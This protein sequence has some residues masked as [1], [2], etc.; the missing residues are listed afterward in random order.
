MKNQEIIEGLAQLPKFLT[1]DWIDQAMNKLDKSKMTP[2]Q[3]MH[4]E[5]MLAKNGSILSMMEE[6]KRN[7]KEEVTK[8]VTKKRAEELA[9][10]MKSNGESIEKIIEYTKLTIE[11]I[12]KLF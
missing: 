2:E 4:F 9:K 8:E 7:L 1:E 6:E 5:M 12:E 11:E 3:R 10:K